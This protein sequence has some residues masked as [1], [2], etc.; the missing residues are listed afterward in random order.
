MKLKDFTKQFIDHNGMFRVLY[1]S[2]NADN[3]VMSVHDW[4]KVSMVHEL[5]RGYSR[6]QPL[7]DCEVVKIRCIHTRGHYPETVSIEVKATDKLADFV[8]NE[9]KAKERDFSNCIE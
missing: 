6:F 3:D 4:D 2:E 8:R 7:E 5:E 9:Y 1:K